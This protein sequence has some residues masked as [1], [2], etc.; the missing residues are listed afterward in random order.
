MHAHQSAASSTIIHHHHFL[1]LGSHPTANPGAEG[2]SVD[3]EMTS[4]TSW[5]DCSK[6]CDGGEMRPA[7]WW[8]E[9]LSREVFGDL[10]MVSWSA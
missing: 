3:C 4:W 7:T 1:S 2:P 10:V 9:P 8:A 5:S 6:S